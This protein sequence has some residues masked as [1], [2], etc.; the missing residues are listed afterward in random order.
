MQQRTFI[1]GS[2]W[3]ILAHSVF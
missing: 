3:V 1:F 2:L